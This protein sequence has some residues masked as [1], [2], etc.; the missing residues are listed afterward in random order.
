MIDFK[1][2]PDWWALC[3]YDDCPRAGECLRNKACKEAPKRFQQWS[4]VL[5]HV[6]KEDGCNYFQKVEEVRMVRGLKKLYDPIR[7]KRVRSDIRAELM[8]CF[9]SN[10]AYYRYRNG[11][12]WIN[13]EMQQLIQNVMRKNG[14]DGE[15]QYDESVITYD[16]TVVP[17][18]DE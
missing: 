15:A 3:P 2:I 5:P 12:R 10:G 4:C 17:K 14:Y 13:P 16:F 6:R 9:G 11:E 7:D 1:N 8:A 18:Q